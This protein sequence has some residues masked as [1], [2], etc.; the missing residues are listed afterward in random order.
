LSFTECSGVNGGDPVQVH[1]AVK[2]KVNVAAASL[3]FENSTALYSPRNVWLMKWRGATIAAKESFR[4]RASLDKSTLTQESPH[5]EEIPP[6]SASHA[7]IH[8]EEICPGHHHGC[9]HVSRQASTKVL[10]LSMAILGAMFVMEVIGGV[11]S[12][13]LALISDA[14]HLLTDVA[15]VALSLFAQWMAKKPSSAERSYGYHRAEILAALLNGFTLLL[16]AVLIGKEAVLR[17]FHPPQV[18]TWP[19]II[20]ASV[21]LVAQTATTLILSKAKSESLNVRSAYLHAMTDAVQS[22]GV[23]GAGLVI[24]FTGI[25][26]VDPLISV[27]ISVLIF[28]SGG[29]II[30]EATHVLIEGTPVG[31]DLERVVAMIRA[32]PGVIQVTDLHAWT[33]TSGYNA[34]S[35]HVVAL[36]SEED[37]TH[38]ALRRHLT[39]ELCRR[40]QLQHVTLQI[41]RDCEACKTGNCSGWMDSS[42]SK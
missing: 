35:A 32:M 25:Y 16:V 15:A 21:G 19:M 14:A 38:E 8:E 5:R 40:F 7:P 6:N 3:M 26:L 20:I 41:E 24:H 27:A 29:K 22:V 4:D 36:P 18:S 2:V 34:F 23:V 33:L 12:N 9:S 28:Y 37:A 11:L 17:F 13:S 1:V 39:E 30:Y 31:M 10:W 42:S